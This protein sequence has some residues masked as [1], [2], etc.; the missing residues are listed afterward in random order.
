MNDVATFP[1]RLELIEHQILT[2]YPDEVQKA[3]AACKLFHH[4]A[5]GV[6]LRELRRP[7]DTYII[8]HAHKTEHLNILLEGDLDVYMDGKL[9]RM[10]APRI[11]LSEANVRKLTHTEKGATLLTIHATD[12]VDIDKLEDE[13]ITK[14][15]S[16]KHHELEDMRRLIAELSLT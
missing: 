16:F 11:F 15:E 8:G 12:E 13:L 10:V 9:S 6:Y 7:A 5:P 4:F 1:D 3:I 14:S 2:R